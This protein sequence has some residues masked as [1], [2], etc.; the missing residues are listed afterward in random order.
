MRFMKNKCNKIQQKNKGVALIWALVFSS[1]VLVM[2]AS[3]SI[4]IVKELRITANIDESTRAYLAAESGM[5][6]GLYNL[7]GYFNADMNWFCPPTG[8]GGSVEF[9]ERILDTS[10]AGSPTLKHKVFIKCSSAGVIDIESTGT[11]LGRTQRKLRT[12]ITF[13]DPTNRI[14]RFDNDPG[15]SGGKY[16]FPSASISAGASLLIQQFDVK[17]LSKITSPILIGM[18]DN[19]GDSVGVKITKSSGNARFSL[20]YSHGWGAAVSP[21]SVDIKLNPADAN[22]GF[23]VKLEYAKYG[24]TYT[25][26][27]ASIFKKNISVGG[28]ESFVCAPTTSALS[29]P[30]IFQ[31]ISSPTFIPFVPQWVVVDNGVRL[32]E[33]NNGFVSFGSFPNDVRV[34][35][36]VFWAKE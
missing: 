15:I 36:M 6:E 3:M 30:I 20:Q 25:V 22:E 13:V 9:P 7:K 26:L 14:E 4:L 5:E 27:R 2:A 31:G 24:S 18:S 28:A 33:N 10:A 35:N 8:V 16:P 12:R 19:S 29:N 1:I 21:T 23:R 32:T 34:D 11:E 17:Q